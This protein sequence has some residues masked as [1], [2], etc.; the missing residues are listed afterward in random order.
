M[1]LRFIKVDSF[2]VFKEL[3]LKRVYRRVL[4][5]SREITAIHSRRVDFREVFARE[6][7]TR[8]SC[9]FY[10][11]QNRD[12]RE[13][14][15]KFGCILILDSVKLLTMNSNDLQDFLQKAREK[16]HMKHFTEADS[17][18]IL[19]AYLAVYSQIQ[20]AL[21]LKNNKGA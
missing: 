3:N 21:A 16:F 15:L 4:F 13:Q 10:I 20:T 11:Y 8:D 19:N 17:Q 6:Y 1:D 9:T 18:A 2:E 14:F 12:T 7:L 5:D